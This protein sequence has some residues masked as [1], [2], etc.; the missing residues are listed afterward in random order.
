[1]FNTFYLWFTI[2]QVFGLITICI[3]FW[4]YQDKR[5]KNYL[6]KTSLASIAWFFCF[7]F[8][9]LA[10]G[11]STSISLLV[12]SSISVI[13]GLG[14]YCFYE[15]KKVKTA[16]FCTVMC[17]ALAGWIVSFVLVPPE[18][19]WLH[20]VLFVTGTLYS[21]SQM[22]KCTIFLRIAAFI[23]AAFV[24]VSMTPLNLLYGDFRWNITGIIIAAFECIAIIF[25]ITRRRMRSYE[26]RDSNS[27][28]IA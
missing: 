28:G 5:P 1:M 25:F 6:L 8:M 22:T 24:M 23:Y 3:D 16:F 4:A 19:L 27:R 20:L 7:L 9:A 15:R 13:R 11:W 17:I 12:I 26:K 14:I 2:A 10:T 21:C 18:V